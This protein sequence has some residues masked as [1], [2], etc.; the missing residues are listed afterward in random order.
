MGNMHIP[1]F[2]SPINDRFWPSR[3]IMEQA[4]AVQ[5]NRFAAALISASHGYKRV[6]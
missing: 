6:T 2:F 1:A 4:L 3:T 5:C